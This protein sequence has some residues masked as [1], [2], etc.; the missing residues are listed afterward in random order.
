MNIINLTD[1]FIY[2]L[3]IILLITN[4]SL[5]MR[6]I[7]NLGSAITLITLTIAFLL[8]LKNKR[9]SKLIAIN[10]IFVFIIN[11]ILKFIIAR[12][13]PQELSLVIEKGY[14]FP[15]G[16]S[17]ISM[18]F[19]GFIIYL[20]YK[21][22]KNKKIKYP[23]IIFLGITILLIGISR[24]YLG[25]HYATDIIGGFIIGFIYLAFF[26]KYIYNNR[27]LKKGF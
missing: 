6:F 22:I 23:L 8:I 19:Y 18:A 7:S 4:M 9:Q 1:K 27:V 20:I 3:I 21:N 12:P 17:M 14:S 24:I 25:V 26:I 11:R 5:I 16:H 13:R 15:S 2:N 10:L